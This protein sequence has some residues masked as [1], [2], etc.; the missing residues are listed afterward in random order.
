M[1]ALLPVVLAGGSGTR[2]WPWA[3]AHRPKALQ[4]LLGEQ[5]LLEETL[6]RI[7]RL[8][9]DVRA[10]WILAGDDY[11]FA[12]AEKARTADLAIGRII[13][14]PDV[15]GT[16]AAIAAAAYLALE[17]GFDGHL[18]IVP[19]DQHVG[20]DDFLEGV[21]IARENA[22]STHLV[23]FGVPPRFAATGYGY[24]EQEQPVA[25]SPVARFVEKPDL[26]TAERY[27]ADKRFLWNSGMFLFSPHA[28]LA[29]WEARD[30]AS[31]AAV[32]DSVRHGAAERDFF[33][34]G[35]RFLDAAS[36]SID[37][38][39]M[40][41]A[42]D[43]FVARYGSSWSDVGTWNAVGDAAGRDGD[44]NVIHGDAVAIDSR[45]SLVYAEAI[46]VG[47]LGVEDL[48]VAATA[49]GVLVAARDREQ[50]VRRIAE[51]LPIDFDATPVIRPWGCYRPVA[52]GAGFLVKVIEVN[53]MSA[54]S[55]QQHAHRAEHWI[56]LRGTASVTKGERAF[57][58]GANESTTIGREE[59]HRLANETPDPL[60]MI[61]VQLGD[62]LDEADIV[63]FEDDYG[64]LP[65]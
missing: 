26:E 12:V 10:P 1:A 19:S 54:L 41:Q 29:V 17:E 11:R 24:V 30:P 28:M 45:R 21:A 53:P 65:T 25:Y 47:L 14:E 58:L 5:S 42:D 64:R 46:R 7:A 37:Y 18:L 43:V 31:S 50:D 48:L 4:P 57:R 60:V 63:R 27:V 3:S 38:A 36:N 6:A 52:H 16:V 33:L 55:L 51:R 20:L 49:G 44:G 56:V 15:R 13:L 35:D 40:E 9:G 8:P 59:R 2:L 39:V 23:T 22:A 34:L 32:L 61:E 62:L